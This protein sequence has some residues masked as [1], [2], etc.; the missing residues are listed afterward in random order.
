MKKYTA[1]F[2]A[3]GV[4]ASLLFAAAC[5]SVEPTAVAAKEQTTE[6]VIPTTTTPATTTKPV[7]TD[8][9]YTTVCNYL[10]TLYD[11]YVITSGELVAVAI[12]VSDDRNVPINSELGT[13]IGMAVIIE[14]DHYMDDVETAAGEYGG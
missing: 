12:K 3:L 8:P 13:Y 1:G 5:S 4:S 11:D 2:A 6:R 9:Y 10:D 14:C 7:S